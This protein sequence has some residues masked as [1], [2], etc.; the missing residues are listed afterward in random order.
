MEVKKSLL[1]AAMIERL[2][3]IVTI[4]FIMTRIGFFR[5]LIDEKHQVKRFQTLLLIIIFG[6]F[7]IIGTYTG[8]IVNPLEDQY[9]KWQ[10]SLQQ[11]EAIANSRVI[12]VVAAG[13]LG[14]WKLG[15]GAGILA[16]GHR[17]FMGGF[18]AL[19]CGISTIIA[20][21][22]AGWVGQ[23]EKRLKLISPKTAFFIGMLAEAIQMLVILLVSKPMEKAYY[24]VSDIGIPM[25]IANG[26]GTG[27]FIL[28]IKSVVQEGERIGAVQSQKALRIADN[29]VKYMRKGLN[30]SSAYY[31]CQI[32]MREVQAVAV[33]ITDRSHILA[34]VGSA[35]DHHKH[36]AFI[37]T[38]ATKKV[39]ET[40]E[41]M[42]V[43]KKMIQCDRS[44]CPLGAA[45]MAPLLKE[46]QVVGTL[47]FYFK[48]E[49]DISSILIELVKGLSTLLSH[50]LELAEVDYHK[51]LAK[52]SE[53][54]ALQAQVN[55]HFLFNTINVIVSLI[56]IDPN[57]ARKL[58]LSLSHFI[59]QN[60]TG[61]TK[62]TSSLKEELGHVKAYLLIEEARFYDRLQI[63]YKIDETALHVQ[64]P[65][66]TLQ[67]LV[68]NSIKHGMKNQ[69]EGFYLEISISSS[70]E[71]VTISVQDNGA[72][73][74]EE[75]LTTLKQKPVKS[76][77]GTGIGLYNVNKRL[78]M[79]LGQ[80]SSLHI[81][82]TVNKGTSITFNVKR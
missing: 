68:E 24:L 18:T 2:G 13:L 50:Q 82:S 23:R 5:K 75:R 48:S 78:E 44:D 28:I 43:E 64:V 69:L 66:I 29:T 42:V 14:G 38:E 36:G 57:K 19:S 61:S 65:S 3:I 12:G 39:I 54:K 30:P 58:L 27:I 60:L 6:V 21:L 72:G 52:Q 49:K 31:T 22:L 41:V 25:I 71:W 9:G 77:T 26:I 4:A 81:Q 76:E 45:I 10:W 59:R 79:M 1:I 53:I 73:I 56:R 63:S 16:G 67:P 80:D 35:S 34:H 20:G 74:E 11:E 55:P 40:G 7:G 32:L 8:L 70:E 47:K 46:G 37:Q 33:S 15:L 62:P 17:Y 51:E